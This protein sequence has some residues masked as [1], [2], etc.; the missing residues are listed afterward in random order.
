[1]IYEWAIALKDLDKLIYTCVTDLNMD[2]KIK[3]CDALSVQFE[4]TE[5]NITIF[6][7]G[8]IKM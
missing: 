8:V 6:A 7:Q 1:L 5:N 4:S 2:G 3:K